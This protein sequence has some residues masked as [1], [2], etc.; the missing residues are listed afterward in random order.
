[1]FVPKTKDFNPYVF[2]IEFPELLPAKLLKFANNT[3]KFYFGIEKS[4]ELVNKCLKY[5][6]ILRVNPVK[7]IKK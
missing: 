5:G 3:L 7:K 1:M 6:I 2:N 4:F